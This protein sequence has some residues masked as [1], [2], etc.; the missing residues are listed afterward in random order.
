MSLHKKHNI[1]SLVIKHKNE[2]HP[3]E[4]IMGHKIIAHTNHKLVVTETTCP[5]CGKSHTSHQL[6]PN[7]GTTVWEI[8][9]LRT[10]RGAY[11]FSTTGF[12]ADHYD[13]Y[14]EDYPVFVMASSDEELV[15]ETVAREEARLDAW[16]DCVFA[17][18][19]GGYKQAFVVFFDRSGAE[20]LAP[21]VIKT[22]KPHFSCAAPLNRDTMRQV[23]KKIR[24]GKANRGEEIAWR[25]Y[26]AAQLSRYAG[27]DGLRIVTGGNPWRDESVLAILPVPENAMEFLGLHGR[28][29]IVR[30]THGYVL[31]VGY[32]TVP[33]DDVVFRI[34][35]FLS[36][37]WRHSGCGFRIFEAPYIGPIPV[38]DDNNQYYYLTPEGE[39]R[40]TNSDAIGVNYSLQPTGAG[41]QPVNVRVGQWPEDAEVAFSVGD[42]VVHYVHRNQRHLPVHRGVAEHVAA[43]DGVPLP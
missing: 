25:K 12:V 19:V 10:P 30:T 21:E 1:I 11:D 22:E 24:L 15:I 13:R 26:V 6:V 20:Q 37:S 34:R 8:K 4:D 18:D 14:D 23:V 41:Y 29:A 32:E 33:E 5:I 9:G 35:E 39:V 31:A 42:G 27:E 28:C 43:L 17:Q 38:Y 2:T 7:T 36:E 40:E 3:K 16:E